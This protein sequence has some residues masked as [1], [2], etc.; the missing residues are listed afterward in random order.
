ML[1]N[2]NLPTLQER[3]RQLRL[4]FL[5]KIIEEKV[6]AMPPDTFLRRQRPK[7]TIRAKK[8]EG[9]VATNIIDNQ[10]RN[11]SKC[12]CVGISASDT[13]QYRNS[14]F[15][16]TVIDWNQLDEELVS[17]TSVEDFRKRVAGNTRH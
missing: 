5:F 17:A 9:H 13:Q 4:T 3:R 2:Q 12:Y 14:F 15:V 1:S 16:R 11:N 10:A 6:P 7:R 8:F